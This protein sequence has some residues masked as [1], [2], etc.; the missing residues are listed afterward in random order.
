MPLIE[1]GH[2]LKPDLKF[3][4]KPSFENIKFAP[5]IPLKFNYEELVIPSISSEDE[6]GQVIYKGF[7]PS[8]SLELHEYL[9]LKTG[10]KI[11]ELL[12]MTVYGGAKELIG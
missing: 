9:S 8:N 11:E 10:K 4:W 1:S 3:G 2:S 6:F 7:R 12:Q 5:K